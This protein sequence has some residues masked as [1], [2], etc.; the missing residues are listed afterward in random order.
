M[1][2]DFHNGCDSRPR[3]SGGVD[4]H[5]LN[6]VVGVDKVDEQVDGDSI[7]VRPWFMN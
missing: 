6:V 1:S 5:V 4:S 7:T 2:S 3:Y